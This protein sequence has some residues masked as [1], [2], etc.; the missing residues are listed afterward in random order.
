MRPSVSYT[1]FILMLTLAT[2][3]HA[4]ETLEQIE[5]VEIDLSSE[6][7]E[8][9]TEFEQADAEYRALLD[10]WQANI[11]EEDPDDYST[12]ELEEMMIEAGS[13]SQRSRR[14]I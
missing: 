1:F 6:I 4:S 2:S 5:Q 9:R 7:E 8:A 3:S 13:S 11:N 12:A 14:K 10:S